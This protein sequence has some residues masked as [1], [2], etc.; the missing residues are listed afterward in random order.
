M[1]KCEGSK[2]YQSKGKVVYHN[3]SDEDD[4]S[5]EDPA[6]ETSLEDCKVKIIVVSHLLEFWELRP[7]AKLRK[8]VEGHIY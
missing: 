5:E 7:P 3:I 4:K 1:R 8:Q 6:E 2:E